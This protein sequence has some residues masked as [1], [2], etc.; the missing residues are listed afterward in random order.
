LSKEKD[1][2]KSRI[3]ILEANFRAAEKMRGEQGTAG[4][5]AAALSS[6]SD[7]KN[8]LRKVNEA[9]DETQKES[10]K[11]D[12]DII[13]LKAET[14][15][16]EYQETETTKK[17]TKAKKEDT[18]ATKEQKEVYDSFL[19]TLKELQRVQDEINQAKADKSQ[20]YT[21]VDNQQMLAEFALIDKAIAKEAELKKATEEFVQSFGDEFVS[22][23]GLSAVFDIVNGRLDTFGDNWQAK[24]E[25][26]MEAVQQMYN[27]I[28]EASQ[29]NFDAEYSR[30]E[31]Q[32]N[33]T[34][35]FAGD[36]ASAKEKIE[37]EYEV[38]RRD[39]ARREAKAKQ[40]QAIFNIAIDTAQAVI[41][42]LAK[43]PPPAGLPLAALMA[44][45]GAAQIAVVS[46]QKIPQYWKGTDNAIG[47]LAWTQ[48]RG[49][50][51]ITDKKGN[52]KD[53]GDSK[54]ARLT[55]LEKGDKVL[56]ASKTKQMMFNND[57]NNMLS[58]SGVNMVIPINNGMTASEMDIVLGKHFS[59]IKT[60]NLNIDKRGFN[61]YLSKNGNLT[62]RTENRANGQGYIF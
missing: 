20:A 7:A 40:K 21:D 51:I 44:V 4:L 59:N 16:L 39:I 25:L 9:Y 11:I 2:L 8:R 47:G 13:K 5:Y 37:A 15:A 12:T 10:I 60:Q 18:K 22:N 52:I 35:Q 36:S 6:L 48:E 41:A 49:Q 23:S 28:N 58:G 31:Q 14:I 54:G 3:P 50:E 26:I 34:L 45:I 57:L 56:N 1:E 42:T 62:K 27:F 17:K 29:K 46:S 19:D 30:L 33:I 61:Y 43:T 32:K 55:M 38:K 53:L 24:T